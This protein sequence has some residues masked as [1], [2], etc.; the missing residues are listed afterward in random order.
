LGRRLFDFASQIYDES[1]FSVVGKSKKS[2]MGNREDA[3]GTYSTPATMRS[4]DRSA[5][6]TTSL[7]WSKLGSGSPLCFSGNQ[8]SS[9]C[10]AG[11][12]EKVNAFPYFAY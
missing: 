11:L 7:T 4:D 10:P 12:Y 6:Y 3:R 2:Q 9:G 5:R 1:Y 8:Y